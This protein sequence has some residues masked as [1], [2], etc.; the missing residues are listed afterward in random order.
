MR[1]IENY[2]N[3]EKIICFHHSKQNFKKYDE[4]EFIF[5]NKY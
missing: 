2:Y 5:N 1:P 3:L 4:L